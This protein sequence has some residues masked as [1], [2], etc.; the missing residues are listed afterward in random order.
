[1]IVIGPHISISKGFA[2][3]A[4]TAVDIGANTFQF[5]SRNPR[6]GNAKVLD[7]KDGEKVQKEETK[8]TDVTKIESISSNDVETKNAISNVD[9]SLNTTNLVNNV[10]NDVILTATLR[11]DD[12]KYSLFRNPTITIEMPAEVEEVVLG[13]VQEMYNNKVFTITSAKVSTNASGNKVITITLAGQQTA[14][15]HNSLIEGTNI[16]IPAKIYVQ[17]DLE[18][19]DTN[20]KLTY[21]NEMA[22][23]TVYS[24]EQKPCEDI[25]VKL[26][27]KVGVDIPGSGDD[28]E[29]QPPVLDTAEGINIEVVQKLGNQVV[30][31]GG[32]L[33]E[34][35]IIKQVLRIT[36]TNSTAKNVQVTAN[37]PEQMTYVE[38]A[39]GG[40]IYHPDG[41]YY[42]FSMQY[43]Y[44]EK[45]DR[46]VT[47]NAGTIAPGA[48]VEKEFELKV[49][50]LP[51][52]QDNVNSSMTFS[53]NGTEMANATRTNVIRQ[54]KLSIE[55]TSQIGNGRKD[56]SYG[57]KV[58][59]LTD[60]E[61]K[62]IDVTL[63]LSP[64]LDIKRAELENNVIG[65]YEGSLFSY[66]IS[67]LKPKN[68]EEGENKETGYILLTVAGIVENFNE[69]DGY[70]YTLNGVASANNPEYGIYISN[71][72]TDKGNIEAVEITMTSDKEGQQ[73]E[74][75]EEI[76]YT[77]TIKNVGKV[78][79]GIATY[80]KVN[81][82]DFFS[83][84]L[85]PISA[86]YND[87][88]LST[89][90]IE[91]PN[92]PGVQNKVENFIEET[93]TRNL[94]TKIVREGYDEESSPNIDWTLTIPEG[95]TVTMVIKAKAKMVF[96]DTTVSNKFVVQGD[97]I[98]TK[99]AVLENEVLS[100]N[101]VPGVDPDDPTDP[102]NPPVD[103]DDPD[104]PVDPDKPETKTVKISGTAWV[105]SE[106]DGRRATT[107]STF[108]GMQVMLFDYKNNEF[109]K[110]DD[111]NLIVTTNDSGYYE[112][113][114]IPEGKYVVVFLYNTDEYSLT[115]YQ[116]TGVSD[117]R[118]SDAVSKTIT[119]DGKETLVGITD[120][121]DAKEDLSDID[122]GL[123]EKKLF[124]MEIQKYINTKKSD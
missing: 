106:E 17:K 7:K 59:N 116:E 54:A 36:N 122:I 32:Q 81:V 50:D 117:M 35:Q 30:Q 48:T 1:M 71:Y 109:V 19:M 55:L 44:I 28:E 5:F 65:G 8:Q 124:D 91:D 52:D 111:S 99:T 74:F 83:E 45:T 53:I 41:N 33:Y 94:T 6:G 14:Y 78:W 13:D 70:E 118:N 37:V 47:I 86:T 114:D 15:E 2:K 26:L 92:Y 27:N 58:T 103:P 93:R 43:E 88:T 42:T 76:T 98:K 60:E 10:A 22:T 84:G 12:P 119:I 105:D 69:D 51:D 39:K 66:N 62:D 107:E 101:Y 95:K 77:V 73:L 75:N 104:I 115:T 89:T 80:T 34:R 120:T 61:L 85:E 25:P 100:Y 67:S 87:F 9:I 79:G 40:Y 112:F 21:T 63:E 29:E 82:Q 31:N 3:A 90:Y 11:T 23:D 49:K 108:A 97:F 123:V 56:W 110:K 38:L 121:L 24:V 20:F 102:D 18:D 4:K 113:T 64:I 57:I 46:Q 16:L 96:N 72:T 68:N